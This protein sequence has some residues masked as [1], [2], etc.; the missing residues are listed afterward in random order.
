MILF[1][2]LLLKELKILSSE[3]TLKPRIGNLMIVCFLSLG[4]GFRSNRLFQSYL[5]K[6]P[7]QLVQTFTGTDNSCNRD[8][9][10]GFKHSF[11]TERKHKRALKQWQ[12]IEALTRFTR[13]HFNRFL[14]LT[15]R[16]LY[17]KKAS[18]PVTIKVAVLF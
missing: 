13:D 7:M 16:F 1:G 17:Q 11:H 12:K 10:I 5:P 8:T 2:M 18:D 15:I 14:V 4:L 6:L 9:A 3:L